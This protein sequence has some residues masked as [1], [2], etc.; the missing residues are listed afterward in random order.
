MSGYLK[1]LSHGLSLTVAVYSTA[2]LQEETSEAIRAHLRRLIKQG[3]KVHCPDSDLHPSLTPEGAI[4][5]EQVA[6]VV[7]GR[8]LTHALR[9]CEE[10]LELAQMC[11][12]VLCCRATP[13]QKVGVFRCM[14]LWY[15][16]MHTT[17]ALD[18][19]AWRIDPAWQMHLQFGLFSVPTSGP[20]LVH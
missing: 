9:D 15:I 14:L 4:A 7:D 20:Q 19:P 6:L 10:F 2:S 11:N 8:T 3:H 1:K 12:A 18:H 16:E 5:F 13:F 17:V